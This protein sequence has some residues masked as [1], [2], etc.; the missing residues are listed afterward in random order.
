MGDATLGWST[1]AR[2]ERRTSDE[3]KALHKHEARDLASPGRGHSNPDIDLA[4]VADNKVY[5]TNDDGELVASTAPGDWARAIDR[6][7]ARVK[8]A[9]FD[10]AEG[11]WYD[12]VTRAGKTTE[13]KRRADRTEVIDVIFQLDP[14][15]T[16]P[17]VAGDYPVRDDS[18]HVVLDEDGNEVTEWH[19]DMTPEKREECERLLMTMVATMTEKVGARNVV[20]VAV[21]WDETH[22]HVHMQL[23]PIDDDG[24]LDWK[25]FING[26]VA[27]SKFHD[28]IRLKLQAEGYD[29]TM[30]RVSDGQKHLGQ[31]KYKARRDAERQTRQEMARKEAK[32]VAKL[33]VAERD[34]AQG[35]AD[36]E[37]AR[38]ELDAAKQD[39]AQAKVELAQAKS[40]LA[41]VV[42]LRRTAKS[43]GRREGYADG[44]RDAEAEAAEML[45]LAALQQQSAEREA[46]LQQRLREATERALQN[47]QEYEEQLKAERERVAQEPADFKAFLDH[48]LPNGKTFRK[49]YEAFAAPRRAR[50]AR[51]EAILAEIRQEAAPV[52][53]PPTPTPKPKPTSGGELG[54]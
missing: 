6:N 18:G 12:S 38:T 17:I 3:A 33:N 29:A 5:V 28:V 1:S 35:K 11:Q 21:Q 7:L 13:R 42:E 37:A 36:R 50:R 25:S 32:A 48:Q 34:L 44:K 54:K 10:A 19:D 14:K 9:R 41:E 23:T 47:A 16:G 26:P 30:E 46:Q 53:G 51:S 31:E 27:T 20:G 43:E 15:F 49:T 4:R 39:R 22:P 2:W 52:T 45:R 40:E 24:K 8:G